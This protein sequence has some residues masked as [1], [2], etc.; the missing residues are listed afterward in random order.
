MPNK[1]DGVELETSLLA[2]FNLYPGAS[3]YQA[4]RVYITDNRKRMDPHILKFVASCAI[5]AGDDWR[6]SSWG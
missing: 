6:Q 5:V 4:A 1:S 3:L 2:E